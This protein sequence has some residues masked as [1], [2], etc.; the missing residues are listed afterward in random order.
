MLADA[1]IRAWATCAVSDRDHFLG[2]TINDF[3]LLLTSCKP[4][5]DAFSDLYFRCVYYVT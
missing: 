2:L 1:H 5:L 4:P 3:P